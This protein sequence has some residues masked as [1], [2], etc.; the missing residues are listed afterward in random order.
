MNMQV[1]LFQPMRRCHVKQLAA[2]DDLAP[3]SN[4]TW[5]F[6]FYDAKLEGNLNIDKLLIS[7]L[8]NIQFLSCKLFHLFLYKL[9]TNNLVKISCWQMQF[10]SQAH[11]W[12]CTCH[13]NL[14]LIYRR[15]QGVGNDKG[16]GLGIHT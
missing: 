2:F 13:K 6:P 8:V 15:E 9:H 12:S 3:L 7:L 16:L 10:N 5:G 14:C 1:L 11:K 4:S